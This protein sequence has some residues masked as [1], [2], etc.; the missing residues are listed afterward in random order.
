MPI[1]LKQMRRY[2]LSF[3]FLL[4][5]SVFAFSQ[6]HNEPQ[7]GGQPTGEH[8]A[9]GEV[10]HGDPGAIDH[11][12]HGTE[13]HDAGCGPQE[14]HEFDPGATAFHHIADQNIY[15]IGPWN[16]PLPCFLYAPDHGW[17]VFSSG[18]F[19][20]DAHGNGHVAV[21]KY[22]LVEGMVQRITDPTF[23]DGEVEVAHH[24]YFQKVK[25]GDGGEKEIASICY[26]S[27]LYPAEDRSTA[28]GGLFGGGITSFYDFSLTKNVTSM[29][30]IFALLSWMFL[31]IAKAYKTRDGMAPKGMQG[32]IE[33][34]FIFI[35][36]EVAKPFLGHK[37]EQYLPFLM[38]LFFFILALNL[39]GQIPFLGGS[40]VSGNLAVTM[41]LA[42]I[43]FLVVNLSGNKNYWEHILWMPGVPA[44]VKVILTP[45]ELLGVFIKP[46]TLMLRLFA[47]ITA[48]H[49][50]MVI[51]VSLIFVF[52]N[53]GINVGAGYGT[54]IGST[55]LTL[56]MMTIELLVAFI[57]AFVFT[58][59]TAS[60]IG[61]A[62]EEAHH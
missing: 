41:V 52:S 24:P 57:Q 9:G 61:A 56:F 14:E 4:S 29:I 40:N 45:V 15:S 28:D 35:Q 49:M 39:F 8:P 27:K 48:G 20:A 2:I 10:E 25:R 26:E 22:V 44:W 37:W 46:M 50:V 6:E 47:N 32:F 34:I 54:A 5:L 43:T 38:A 16:F 30:F 53:N 23:P 7:S 51:F 12:D 18:K 1:K 13:A 55:L 62:T 3:I 17:S 11:Q 60:Y 36:D 19:H 31:S 42:I 58:I 21:D 59:L 33:P